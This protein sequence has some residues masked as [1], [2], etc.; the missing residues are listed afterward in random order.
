VADVLTAAEVPFTWQQLLTG[1]PLRMRYQKG[2]RQKV[3]PTPSN[4]RS[5][6]SK[7]R[8]PKHIYFTVFPHDA[9]LNAR[10]QRTRII[11]NLI[12]MMDSAH[13]HLTVSALAEEHGVRSI[14]VVHDSFGV[15]AEDVEALDDVLRRLFA[16]LYKDDVLARLKDDL[17][18]EYRGKGLTLPP[19]K[20]ERGDLDQEEVLDSDYFSA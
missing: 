16:K 20:P 19:I 1:F 15:L 5:G 7:S 6:E 17:E 8:T 3:T 18:A 14:G 13:L 2:D 10:K 12:H 9:K 4:P 11:P